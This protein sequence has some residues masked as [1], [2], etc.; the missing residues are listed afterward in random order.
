MPRGTNAPKLCPAEPVKCSWMVS[1]GSPSAPY[2][3]VTSLPVIVP[4][5]RL[6]LRIGSVASTFSPRSIAGLHSGRIVVM[7]SDVVEPV[8]LRLGLEAP[9]LGADVG[10]VEDLRE[11]EPLRLPVVDGRLHLDAARCGRPSR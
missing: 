5:T 6:T 4:T 7:S 9:D 1:S 3:R 8:V 11:V 2:L 10:L